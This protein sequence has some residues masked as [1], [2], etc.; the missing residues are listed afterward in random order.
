MRRDDA[1][2]RPSKA[3]HL[4]AKMASSQS[5]DP[6]TTPELRDLSSEHQQIVQ[7]V[8]S[9]VIVAQ[10]FDPSLAEDETEF[11][12]LLSIMV[13]LGAISKREFYTGMRQMSLKDP[14]EFMRI[15]CSDLVAIHNRKRQRELELLDLQDSRKRT[16][17][18]GM[19]PH[20]QCRGTLVEALTSTA[21]WDA[22]TFLPVLRNTTKSI[23]VQVDV[24]GELKERPVL[25]REEGSSWRWAN[26]TDERRDT[27]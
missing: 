10:E 22:G 17:T 25:V 14:D 21:W 15:H 19:Q 26:S 2:P 7:R 1:R 5:P 16:R 3:P 12:H 9:A 13:G 4:L 27:A 24:H 8:R 6:C 20:P 23:L 11:G 18:R